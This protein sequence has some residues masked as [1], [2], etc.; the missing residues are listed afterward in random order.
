MAE[1]LGGLGHLRRARLD[2]IIVVE[3]LSLGIF[4]LMLTV[5]NKGLGFRV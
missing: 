5:L 1:A 3:D 2:H 4:T